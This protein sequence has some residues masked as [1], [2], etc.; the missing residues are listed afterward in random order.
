MKKLSFILLFVAVS[1]GCFAQQVKPIKF[2]QLQNRYSSV[3]DTTYIINFWAT[4]CAPCIKELPNFVQLQEQY[5]TDK[6]KVILVS[7]DFKSK[8]ESSVQ[9]FV[10][11][12]KIPLEVLLLDEKDQ[13]AV[14]DEVDKS[15]SGALPGTLIIN[16]KNDYRKFYERDFNFDE[17]K[18]AYLLTKN[19]NHETIID[20]CS[21]GFI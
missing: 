2:S 13:G 10:K 19:K 12:N 21:L 3:N 11:R 7:M 18:D 6:L 1:T 20:H 4:W 9:P 8:L 16:A 5:R 14:I 15:W 17:L